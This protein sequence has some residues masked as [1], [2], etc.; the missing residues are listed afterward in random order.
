MA[1]PGMVTARP[2]RDPR[3]MLTIQMIA[4]T[5]ITA[6]LRQTPGAGAEAASKGTP[7]PAIRTQRRK[8]IQMTTTLSTVN[9]WRLTANHCP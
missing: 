8:M 9:V 2:R 4:T 5:G 7:L 3:V 1:T 6:V